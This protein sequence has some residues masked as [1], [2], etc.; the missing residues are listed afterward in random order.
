MSFIICNKPFYENLS[1]IIFKEKKSKRLTKITS[2]VSDNKA[3]LFHIKAILFIINKCKSISKIP[4]S[5]IISC[6]VSLNHQ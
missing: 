4:T 1:D 2:T 5:L 3:R 6:S